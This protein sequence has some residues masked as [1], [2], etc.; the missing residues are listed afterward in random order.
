MDKKHV[1]VDRHEDQEV[2]ISATAPDV[3]KHIDNY[4]I[5]LRCSNCYNH[6]V[7][8]ESFSF[9]LTLERL[10]SAV[11]IYTKRNPG[12]VIDVTLESSPIVIHNHSYVYFDI[13]ASSISEDELKIYAIKFTWQPLHYITIENATL[14][15]IEHIGLYTPYVRYVEND[16]KKLVASFGSAWKDDM[17]YRTWKD[18]CLNEDGVFDNLSEQLYQVFKGAY[19][20]FKKD[21]IYLGYIDDKIDTPDAVSATEIIQGAVLSATKRLNGYPSD[22]HERNTKCV[23]AK[24]MWYTK[25]LKGIFNSL[26]ENDEPDATAF[27]AAMYDLCTSLKDPVD[28]D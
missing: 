8:F 10:V 26:K 7:D 6:V 16:S 18:T 25:M 5:Y 13:C 14:T 9:A 1:V 15:T 12:K 3:F 27:F 4:E 19:G 22:K 21:R 28:R 24:T 23:G 17:T 11:N 2:T 20:Q